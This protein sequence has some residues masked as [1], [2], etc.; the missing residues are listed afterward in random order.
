MNEE[1]KKK[2]ERKSFVPRLN[3][4][5]Q[6]Y[7]LDRTATMG[8]K[9]EKKRRREKNRALNA[10]NVSFPRW[11]ERITCN[12]RSLSLS[13]SSL[14]SFGSDWLSIKNIQMAGQIGRATSSSIVAALESI[15]TKRFFGFLK[16]R[17]QIWSI[18]RIVKEWQT[19]K[20]R[21]VVDAKINILHFR[22]IPQSN[23][24]GRS[25]HSLLCTRSGQT[26][27]SCKQRNIRRKFFVFY[28]RYRPYR[29][30]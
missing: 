28:M 1:K 15:F 18:D 8:T 3:S 29:Q 26:H 17:R 7:Q 11:Q 22:L 2:K 27:S 4:M 30:R 10:Q 21:T 6:K 5:R 24:L 13:L 14:F 9:E 25:R 12:W 20:S 19:E 16:G 23:S